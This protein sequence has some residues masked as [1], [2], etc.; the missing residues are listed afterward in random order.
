M[1]TF[2]GNVIHT[3]ELSKAYKGVQALHGLNLEV[4]K[5]SIF[6]FLG[7]NGAGK[8]TTIKML[9]ARRASFAWG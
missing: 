2:N 5:N 6:G 9:L 4:P 8:S 1:N 7:P 3:Q